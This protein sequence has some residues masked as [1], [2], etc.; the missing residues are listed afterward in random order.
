MND[1]LPKPFTKEGM[2]RVLEKHLAA[3][4]TPGMREYGIPVPPHPDSHPGYVAP[5]TANQA[6]GMNIS[7]I[8]APQSIKD[9]SPAARSPATSWHSPNSNSM[10]CPSPTS[11]GTSDGFGMHSLRQG[12]N[13]GYHMAGP[14]S[15]LRNNLESSNNAQSMAAPRQGIQHRR[16]MSDMTNGPEEH[17]EAKR[18]RLYAPQPPSNNVNNYT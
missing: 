1:I 6:L 5:G 15:G 7:H 3:L 4:K 10:T 8:S 13:S 2:L 16:V 9:D 17:S 12:A 18:Q 14:T 11:A